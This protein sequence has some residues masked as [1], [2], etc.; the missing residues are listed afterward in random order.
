MKV[1]ELSFRNLRLTQETIGFRARY[2][3]AFLTDSERYSQMN[4]ASLRKM[5]DN[6]PSH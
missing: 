3:N 4:N 2:P 5:T 1:P 6:R